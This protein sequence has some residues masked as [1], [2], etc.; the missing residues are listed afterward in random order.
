M[1]PLIAVL[2]AV[3]LVTGCAGPAGAPA[4]EQGC[5]PAPA[6]GPTEFRFA[7]NVSIEDRPGYRVL[8]VHRP[9]PGAA[10]QS[11]VLV[12]CDAPDPELPPQLAGAAVLRT[13]VTGLYSAS[14]TQ[15]PYLSEL[16]VLDR[17]TGVADP[18]LVNDPAVRARIDGGGV[19]TFAPGGI[20]NAEQ[21]IADGPGVL[22]SQ[23]TDDPAFPALR[24]ARVPVLGWA[25]YLESGPLGQ[26]EWIKVMGALTGRDA[27]A[28]AAFDRIAARY[29][30][31]AATV[32]GQEP[33]P[34]VAGQPYQGSWNVPAGGSTTG[35]LLR[36]AG[37]GWSGAATSASGSLPRSLE[38]VL[39]ADGGARIWL[40]DGPWRTTAD[41]AATDPRLRRIA[42][43]GPG[44]QVW[45]RD[46]LTGPGGG[47]QIYERG[48]AHPEEVLADLVAILHPTLLPGHE[49]V[50]YRQV[51][52]G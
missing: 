8:T 14:T 21:V 36:D 32:R 46:K 16:G 7:R 44:G 28:S 10:P 9:Y 17:L 42:A 52:A 26:A 2:S 51:P 6:A 45:T 47:S 12:S 11:L 23:G 35:T 27:E 50:F 15:L 34:I 25:D 48:V 29:E 3:V 19:A 5:T 30:E 22:L 40:A 39:A 43:A 20:T 24:A 31:V 4:A 37:A 13:P 49:F 41:I 1:G 18:A 38:S 33:T